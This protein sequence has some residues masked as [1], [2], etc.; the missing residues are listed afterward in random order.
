MGQPS[1]YLT[2]AETAEK[3]LSKCG[4]DVLAQPRTFLGFL[5]DYMDPDS[6]EL[7]VLER[8]CD[9]DLLRPYRDAVVGT[10]DLGTA[11]ARAEDYLTRRCRIGA[12][13]AELVAHGMAAGVARWVGWRRSRGKGGR[14][15]AG[16][17]V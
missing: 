12:Q 8:N 17:R 14:R 5:M 4:A 16:E 9:E 15:R 10:S 7:C 1:E 3:S 2:L 13:D 11:A 6:V